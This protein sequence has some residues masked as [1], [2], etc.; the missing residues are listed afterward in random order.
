MSLIIDEKQKKE[1]EERAKNLISKR[2]IANS[3]NTVNYA[4]M[5]NINL[6]PQTDEEKS[7]ISKVDRANSLINSINPRED[8]S[9][10]ILTDE[11]K[12]KSEEN[13]KYFINLIDKNR[14]GDENAFNQ[15]EVENMTYGQEEDNDASSRRIMAQASGE[16][17]IRES[18]IRP[19]E[20]LKRNENMPL[21]NKKLS[22]NSNINVDQ[23]VSSNINLA[24]NDTNDL[25][26]NVEISIA[27]KVDTNALKTDNDFKLQ[28]EKS[29]K[30]NNNIFVKGA[31]WIKDIVGSL[32]VSIGSKISRNRKN[33]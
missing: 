27:N 30:E 9:E 14:D 23:N 19:Q 25:T 16:R 21:I 33:Y 31:I 13:I 22:E 15:N 10:P 26:K 3:I 32:G 29:K 12:A 6:N 7:F 11:Q 2:N 20:E 8:V 18:E 17:I 28:Q 1:R 4:K 5:K 24:Q